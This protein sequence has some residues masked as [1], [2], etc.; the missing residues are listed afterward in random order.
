MIEPRQTQRP[1]TLGRTVLCGL[2]LT[3]W[4]SSVGAREV[5]VDG[6]AA[7][8]GSEIVLASEIEEMTRPVILRMRAANVAE[9]EITNLRKDALE[10]LIES[11][12]ID[13]VVNQF[14][15]SAGDEEIDQAIAG[16]AQETG[17]SLT[18]L[19]ESVAGYG[20]SFSDYRAKIRAEIE[21]N[22]VLNAMV[23]SKVQIDPLEVRD[24]FEKRYGDQPSGGDEVHLRHIIVSFGK[25]RGIDR[26][27]ACDMLEQARAR[28]VSGNSSFAEMA[29]KISDS[30]REA[31]GDLGWIHINELAGWMASQLRD[32]S[33]TN[34]ITRVI[35]MPFGCNLLQ[36]VDRRPFQPMTLGE[37]TPI[38]E[39]ELY[40]IKTEQEYSRWVESLRKRTYIERMGIYAASG[41]L[42]ELE[43]AA[44]K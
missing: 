37:A 11:R 18:Q 41:V 31:G 17:L 16:I 25:E 26:A 38:L 5:L 29:M 14:G 36:L 13:D 42:V 9:S 30:N 8:V 35:D 1:T 39:N 40:Q 22:K 10:R 7:Q 28:I 2:A 24:L 23:R 3:C 44:G 32:L 19:T 27:A 21:R 20:M 34:P 12:L 33:R 43:P 6:I 4:V 15:F